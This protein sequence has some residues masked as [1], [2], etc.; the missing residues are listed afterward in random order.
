M[1]ALNLSSEQKDLFAHINSIVPADGHLVYDFTDAKQFAFATLMNELSGRTRETFPGSYQLLDDIKNHHLEHGFQLLKSDDP[2][3]PWITSFDVL[4]IGA[5]AA[6]YIGANGQGTV[7]GGAVSINLALYVVDSAGN[8]RAS[9]TNEGYTPITTVLVKTSNATSGPDN[10]MTAYLDYNY[11]P[12]SA[13]LQA[14]AVPGASGVVVKQSPNGPVADPVVTSPV[15]VSTR[16]IHPNSIN[17]G[18]GRPWTVANTDLDYW[19]NESTQDHP[20]GRIPFAGNVVFPSAIR[21]LQGTNFK[22]TIKVTNTSSGGA[23]TL[24]PSDIAT[25]NAAFNID[26]NNPNNLIWNLPAGTLAYPPGNPIV[27]N[28]IPWT[29]DLYAYFTCYIMV[30]LASGQPAFATIASSPLPDVDPLDGTAYIMPLSFV[31]HCLAGGTMVTLQDGSKKAIEDFVA[32]DVVLSDGQTAT[33]RATTRG[34]HPGAVLKITFEQYGELHDVVTTHHHAFFKGTEMVRANELQPGDEIREVDGTATV[35][36]VEELD[37]YNYLFHNLVLEK[38]DTAQN[39]VGTFY[40]NGI[41]VGDA[42]A[43]QDLTA[44]RAADKEWIKGQLDTY[45]ATDVESHFA[46]K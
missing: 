29:S 10:N 27:F 7:A 21:Q 1:N 8:V 2:N 44:Q 14:G 38:E 4:D 37:G 32:G 25:V 22:I 36:Q 6:N 3:D 42:Y 20:I 24:L 30:T 39:K 16:P 43:Q 15:R 46:R 45:W 17:I 23:A 9:G 13:L 19:W 26:P 12:Q 31:W 35:Q 11:Q 40:A 34:V 5:T 28:S 41:L 33:V 18:L